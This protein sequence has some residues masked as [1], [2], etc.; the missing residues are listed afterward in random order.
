VHEELA[1]TTFLFSD[2]EGSTRLWDQKPDRMQQALAAHDRI[3]RQAVLARGGIVVKS[4]GDGV[5]AAFQ[6]AGDGLRAALDMQLALADPEAT[7]GLALTVRC[8]L[9]AGENQRRDNDFYGPEVNRAARVMSVAHGGQTLLSA[10]VASRVQGDLPEAVALRDLGLVRL[11]DLS[12]P[13]RVYQVV[14]PKLRADFPPLR[15][16][17]ATPNNLAQQLNSFVGRERETAE[18][19][20]M[21]AAG[22]LVTLLGMGGIGKS[23]LSVQLGAEVMN[24]HADGVWLVELAALSDPL[25]VS[26]A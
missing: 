15:S 17:E 2:I 24:D 22:R 3:V 11:R 7:N 9:H 21:L 18:V 1:I 20:L 12:S 6:R 4:T 23:R 8:G 19:K 10:A 14:H 26:Q 5:H 13:E 16:L 25:L